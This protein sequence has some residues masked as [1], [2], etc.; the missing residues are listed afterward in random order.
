[1]VELWGSVYRS[2]GVRPRVGRFSVS[3]SIFPLRFI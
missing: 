3:L 1:M 2:K